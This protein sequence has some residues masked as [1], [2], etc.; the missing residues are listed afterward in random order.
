M[1][2]SKLP[3][4]NSSGFIGD[5]AYSNVRAGNAL[6]LNGVIHLL[7]YLLILKFALSGY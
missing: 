1:P 3:E 2:E 7:S 5:D 6:E 4:S